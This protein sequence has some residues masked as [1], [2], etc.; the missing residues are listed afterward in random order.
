MDPQDELNKIKSFAAQFAGDTVKSTGAETVNYSGVLYNVSGS[1]EDP[2]EV[3]GHE[4]SS[5]KGLLIEIL[6]LEDANCYVTNGDAP[7]SSSH[8][9]FSVGGH[10]TANSDGS[11]PYG[12][13]SYLM[14]LCSW[15]NSTAR[16]GKPFQHDETLMLKL[17]GYMQGDTPALFQA[18]LRA[19]EPYSLLY[20]DADAGK[21]MHTNI[22]DPRDTNNQ[23]KLPRGK[24]T[25][26]LL[27]QRTKTSEGNLSV[28]EVNLP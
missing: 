9:N 20:L 10:M 14:P 7:T 27:L 23:L 2:P 25:P 21:W 22:S 24:A 16:N 26:F 28:E 18:R 15:H 5:W 13:D 1:S 12:G 4:G 6:G 17:T 19:P 3:P 8:A 11:V